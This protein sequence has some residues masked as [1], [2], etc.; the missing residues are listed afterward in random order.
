M[1]MLQTVFWSASSSRHV[2][3]SRLDCSKSKVNALA[4]GLIEQGLLQ[5]T[6]LQPSSGGRR[7]ETLQLAHGLGVVIGVDLGATSLDVA[8]MR[9]DLTVLASRGEEADV[10]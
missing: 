10:R 1:E 8:V 4:A 9:P 5:E 3:A 2:L 7:P 6:G